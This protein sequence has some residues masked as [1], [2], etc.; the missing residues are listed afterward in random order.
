MEFGVPREVRDFEYR[1]GLTPAG[2][3]ALVN[4]GNRVYVQAGAG[5]GAGFPDDEYRK[6]GGEVLYSAEEVFG[7]AE[8][9]L[10]GARFPGLS[11]RLHRGPGWSRRGGMSTS[12]RPNSGRW[13]CMGRASG[14]GRGC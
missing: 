6:V 5:A 1:V 3:Y 8:V 13:I 10:K 2:V 11:R 12:W 9:M 4:A 7:R 14:R